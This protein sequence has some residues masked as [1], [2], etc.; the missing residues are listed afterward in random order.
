MS[1][2]IS[3]AQLCFRYSHSAHVIDG[4]LVVV[5][6]VWLHSD[7]IPGVLIISLTTLVSMEFHLDTVLE[8]HTMLFIA[9]KATW[10]LLLYSDHMMKRLSNELGCVLTSPGL[11]T[12]AFD[13]SLVL[14]WASW[15]RSQRVAPN[16]WG[17]KL[18]L[19]WDPLQLSACLCEPHTAASCQTSPIKI[20]ILI[21]QSAVLG[22]LFSWF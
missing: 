2:W 17:R 16:W 15:P 10:L 12:L 4:N 19:L 6:G 5:G 20:W 21:L 1:L 3:P 8:S 11:H 9:S 13:A 7:G 22:M 18:F 14:L